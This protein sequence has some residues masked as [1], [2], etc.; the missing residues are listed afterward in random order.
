[1][2]VARPIHTAILNEQQQA[3]ERATRIGDDFSRLV[4]EGTH[5]QGDAGGSGGTT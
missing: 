5:V 1:M 3:Q 4:L 2:A